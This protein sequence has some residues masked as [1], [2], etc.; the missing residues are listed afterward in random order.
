[1]KTQ[2]TRRTRHG[3]FRHRTKKLWFWILSNI[4]IIIIMVI[5]D[6]VIFIIIFV[7]EKGWL[8]H[9]EKLWPRIGRTKLFP[10]KWH[11]HHQ[12]WPSFSSS[13]FNIWIQIFTTNFHDSFVHSQ[14]SSWNVGFCKHLEVKTWNS[15]STWRELE[16]CTEN[17]A[18]STQ[19]G[20]QIDKNKTEFWVSEIDPWCDLSLWAKWKHYWCW[21]FE[22]FPMVTIKVVTLTPTFALVWQEKALGLFLFANFFENK[23]VWVTFLLR[24][25]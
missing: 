14:S 12:T 2:I 24:E 10:I 11:Q 19:P 9:Q 8:W 23:T 20:R 17:R 22:S 6:K 25:S 3:C 13:P 21:C 15:S 1:M 18:S 16:I 4:I 5:T 7:F